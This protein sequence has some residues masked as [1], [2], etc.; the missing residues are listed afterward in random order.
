MGLDDVVP[1]DLENVAYQFEVQRIVLDDE[2]PARRHDDSEE[3]N[4][5]YDPTRAHTRRS[6]STSSSRR[7]VLR[8]YTSAP[9]ARPWDRSSTTEAMTTGIAA[10]AG[11]ALSSASTCQPSSRG[12]RMSSTTAAGS[13][14]R[15]S[16]SASTPSRARSTRV[17]E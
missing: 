5:G 14:L 16:S 15:T 13:T 1:S 7:I 4:P 10:V 2:D 9:R 11:S 6:A 17:G 12:S 3:L 8:R